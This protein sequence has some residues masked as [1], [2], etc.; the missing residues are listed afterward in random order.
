MVKQPIPIYTE[1]VKKDTLSR[2]ARIEGQVR[3][4]AK[5]LEDGRSGTE[6]LQQLA[7]IQA[8]LR[9]VS[10]TILRNYLQCCATDPTKSD[11]SEMYD[12]LID[13]IYKFAK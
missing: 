7:S 13:V 11:D 1:E 9:G 10:K 8:S 12:Q 6:I 4:V 3:G 5:M 2:L